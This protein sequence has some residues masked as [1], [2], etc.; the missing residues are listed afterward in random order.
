[1][2]G[3]LAFTLVRAADAWLQPIPYSIRRRLQ[4]R[5]WPPPSRLYCSLA[6]KLCEKESCS[7]G[8]STSSHGP[9][10]IV[11]YPIAS[12]LITQATVRIEGNDAVG[13]QED[14][15]SKGDC[16]SNNSVD[17]SQQV[18]SSREHHRRIMDYGYRRQWREAVAYLATIP[19]PNAYHFAAV[20]TVCDKAQEPAAALSV[21]KNMIASHIAPDGMTLLPLMNCLGRAKW[22]PEV[23]SVFPSHVAVFENI[24]SSDATA[25]SQLSQGYSMAIRAAEKIGDW[26]LAIK[27][28]EEALQVLP[29]LYP[30]TAASVFNACYGAQ[31]WELALKY[32]DS[33]IPPHS[34]PKYSVTLINKA[35][36][37]CAKTAAYSRGLS[38][39]KGI[40]PSKRD[41]YTYG[42]A[43]EIYKKRNSTG[44][45]QDALKLLHVAVQNVLDKENI[46]NKSVRQKESRVLIDKGHGERTIESNLDIKKVLSKQNL[47]DNRL[48][49]KNN[50]VYIEKRQDGDGEGFLQNMLET[51][52]SENE[53]INSLKLEKS[54][55]EGIGKS[56]KEEGAAIEEG[57]GVVGV[58]KVEHLRSTINSVLIL[59]SK[60]GQ[61]TQAK[62]LFRQAQYTWKLPM[63]QYNFG[64]MAVAA[65][66]NE[67]EMVETLLREAVES[68]PRTYP[69]EA[70]LT[71]VVCNLSKAGRWMEAKAVIAMMASYKMRITTLH[72]SALVAACDTAGASAAVLD[73]VDN[74]LKGGLIVDNI[75]INTM[76]KAA[77]LLGIE[78]TWRKAAGLLARADAATSK[79]MPSSNPHVPANRAESWEGL[80]SVLAAR[81]RLEEVL[82]VLDDMERL[83][84]GTITA[85]AW[86]CVVV[87]A[88]RGGL[89]LEAVSWI[90]RLEQRGKPLS[91]TAYN[92]AIS[93]CRQLQRPDI[94][95]SVFDR[96]RG[97]GTLP[98]TVAY[99][100]MLAAA[101]VP[102]RKKKQD[103]G[104]RKRSAAIAGGYAG[105][106]RRRPEENTSTDPPAPIEEE[107]QPIPE[108][109]QQDTGKLA[110]QILRTMPSEGPS[111]PDDITYATVIRALLLSQRY[112]EVLEVW[113]DI[114]V[115]FK[116]ARALECSSI[117][118]VLLR[119]CEN[120]GDGT[121]ALDLLTR[122]EYASS[123][124][125]DL[126]A[127]KC[128]D[129]SM[130][131]SV[132][133][134]L[135][136]ENRWQD[137]ILLLKHMNEGHVPQRRGCWTAAAVCVANAVIRGGDGLQAAKQLV[138]M[139]RERFGSSP[140]EDTQ[141]QSLESIPDNI[142]IP[143]SD[144]TVDNKGIVTGSLTERLWLSSTAL[145][146]VVKAL[147]E[148]E[149][150]K[151]VLDA[152]GAS[153]MDRRTDPL[154]LELGVLAC[155]HLGGTECER[156]LAL[157]DIMLPLRLIP[158]VLTV[159]LAI[160]LLDRHN[161]IQDA[162]R[163]YGDWSAIIWPTA[164][165]SAGS[166]TRL[167][168]SFTPAVARAAMGS[169]LSNIKTDH[170]C[171]IQ[172]PPLCFET[173]ENLVTVATD[174]F[175]DVGV[176]TQTE[177]PRGKDGTWRIDI[178]AD[179]LLR[180][181]ER[182]MQV[183]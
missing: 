90:D 54:S 18:L 44:D 57:A 46:K 14:C 158:S 173:Q 9:V 55:A 72:Y 91:E 4:L 126:R 80:L 78:N 102:P 13:L 39:L 112:S 183:P 76:L 139:C 61:F 88:Y 132:M 64:I 135:S 138:T 117:W 24:S 133:R 181:C 125:C 6:P 176:N 5:P 70:T 108:I 178:S 3:I 129:A 10:E 19:S 107:E 32:V 118:R 106:K 29:W 156:A 105:K 149:E 146:P 81:G 71:A 59:L 27:L 171:G 113:R 50:N 11:I 65:S 12:K 175:R 182:D 52:S 49:R 97:R 42:A 131:S 157:L 180:W 51:K 41:G 22:Y 169:V 28:H 103:R 174:F 62:Q 154:S 73:T 47:D 85:A 23:L 83:S 147:S 160:E 53:N 110:L 7:N 87:A 159:T 98:S 15:N 58:C 124:E 109:W 172:P 134:A 68:G 104:L 16:K 36:L 143:P 114:P 130:Y 33:A 96:L 148:L 21:Y 82:C 34:D 168:R 179:E 43:I 101:C 127:Y 116:S 121:S 17:K 93:A 40:P 155:W 8:S 144:S 152:L 122:M 128:V 136:A 141:T 1:M 115:K 48:Q 153:Q 95:L 26:Q 162:A 119:A 56:Y 161:R 79:N 45:A 75:T 38:L 69:T 89:G 37:A 84:I 67:P 25:M 99:N 150:W 94:A 77:N 100:S 142:D 120:L 137:C 30:S 111:A 170:K 66:E 165:V 35:M 63:D 31:K 163:V 20:L 140:E 166:V 60:Q 86:D 164:A 167:R 145:G 151:L 2:W 123:Q 74:M 92:A 177:R